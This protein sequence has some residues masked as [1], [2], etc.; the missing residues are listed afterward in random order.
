MATIDD[1]AIFPIHEDQQFTPAFLVAVKEMHKR[2]FRMFAHL[3]YAHYEQI[4]KMGSHRHLNSSFKHFILF[5][6]EFQLLDAAT[7]APLQQFI[8]HITSTNSTV[9]AT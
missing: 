4:K 8:D 1:Q 3:Y 9:K 6:V 7:M 2:M 5:A